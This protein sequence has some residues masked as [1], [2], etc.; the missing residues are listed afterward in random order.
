MK[1]GRADS[2]PVLPVCSPSSLPRPTSA[3]SSSSSGAIRIFR[4]RDRIVV[5][6]I[7]FLVRLYRTISTALIT[8][9]DEAPLSQDLM[10]LKSVFVP[11]CVGSIVAGAATEYTKTRPYPP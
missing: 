10:I 7:D 9:Y 8:S 4:F 2:W 1:N 3:S 11:L 6:A 5:I